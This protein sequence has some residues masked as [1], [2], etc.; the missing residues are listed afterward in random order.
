MEHLS[1]SDKRILITGGGGYLGSKLA[2][3]L[4]DSD[5]SLFLQDISFNKISKSLDSLH[6]N[7][8]LIQTDLRDFSAVKESIQHVKPDII[9]H[10]AAILDRNRDFSLYEKLY[11]VNVG[12]TLNIL[13]ALGDDLKLRFVFSS[14]SEVYGSQNK[15]PFRED[16][17]PQPASPYS[18][19]KY[20]AEG[21]ITTY[22]NQHN[23]PFT[24]L[25]LFNFYGDDMPENFFLSQL[26]GALERNEEFPMTK[27]EQIRDFL[28]VEDMVAAILRLTT[29]SKSIGETINVCS[30][31]GSR[32]R[33]VAIREAEKQ[34]KTHL[35]K[36]GTLPYRD[37][38]VWEMIGD[39][40][41]M[42][43]MIGKISR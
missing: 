21:L 33:D 29:S 15:S 8:S 18:L 7:V 6:S 4:I 34:G 24:I 31:K 17:L 10:F 43:R 23:I 40:E 25:R 41:K 36:V 3:S 35:L 26:K 1:F 9:F 38:E 32:L 12:G 5:C 37:N 16:Q 22:C 2:V 27:G 28:S 19:T 13:R 30:G 39:N 42:K 14:S 20:M 11:E